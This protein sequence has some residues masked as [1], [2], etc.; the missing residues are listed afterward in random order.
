MNSRPVA[1]PPL[2]FFL[3]F[4]PAYILP[5]RDQS[6]YRCKQ[7]PKAKDNDIKWRCEDH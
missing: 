5:A 1:L 4:P 7:K 2:V 6:C 3:A